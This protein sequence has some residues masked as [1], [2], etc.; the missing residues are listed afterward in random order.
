MGRSYYLDKKGLEQVLNAIGSK[1]E[2][3]DLLPRIKMYS[4]KGK[5]VNVLDESVLIPTYV[6]YD[7]GYGE[8]LGVYETNS[9]SIYFRK[10][11][12]YEN[13]I[14]PE[15]GKPYYNKLYL[16][17]PRGRKS[18]VMFD[19]E[20]GDTIINLE[21]PKPRPAIL[22]TISGIK[23]KYIRLYAQPDMV[24]ENKDGC[25]YLRPR[26]G[27]DSM[28]LTNIYVEVGEGEPKPLSECNLTFFHRGGYLPPIRELDYPNGIDKVPTG[29]RMRFMCVG[30]L[31]PTKST[32]GNHNLITVR[33]DGLG[34]LVFTTFSGPDIKNTLA[35]PRIK[36]MKIR[37][38]LPNTE[39]DG[40]ISCKKRIQVQT[41]MRGSHN[42]R[43]YNWR[44]HLA[45]YPNGRFLHSYNIFK[46]SENQQTVFVRVRNVKGKET[47]EWV[48]LRI[49]R[50][51]TQGDFIVSYAN[52]YMPT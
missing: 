20:K 9:E 29:Y 32:G 12:G 47:S 38:G 24:Y 4:L 23:R 28:D 14:N 21:K 16:S 51:G 27:E 34:R 17:Y 44:R 36:D 33:K 39:K 42:N 25:I 31:H 15:T 30:E 35:P 48:Y 7:T 45:R 43:L 22:P 13:Y 52:H 2:K 19:N 37:L 49:R 41:W 6:L 8:M 40:V 3:N 26:K 10:W 46:M 5:G 11:P 50:R 1:I 18:L